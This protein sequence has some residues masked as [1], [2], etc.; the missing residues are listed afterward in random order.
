MLLILVI[1]RPLPA[2]GDFDWDL[3]T[4][5]S[6]N[7]SLLESL[8]ERKI[9]AMQADGERYLAQLGYRNCR[10]TL[11]GEWRSGVFVPIS[12][13]VLCTDSRTEG[14]RKAAAEYYGIESEKVVTEYG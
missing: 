11:Y 13:I 2:L 8:N 7:D 3:G 6:P 9:A 12:A 4:E 5:L 1:L 10:I 14:V